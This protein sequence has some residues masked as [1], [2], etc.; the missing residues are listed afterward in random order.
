MELDWS[1]Q[2]PHIRS[3]FHP[4]QPGDGY[5]EA[6][7]QAAEARL[8]VRLPATLRNFYKAWGRRRD[9][10]QMRNPLLPPEELEIR[11]DTLIFWVENQ[12][13]LY[14]G[15]PSAALEEAEALDEIGWRF[16]FPWLKR[17]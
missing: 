13:V 6:T 2:S 15:V 5:D 8:G 11:E 4:W 16:R 10:T 3:L 12:A 14:W 17:W 9:M 7:I 1:A